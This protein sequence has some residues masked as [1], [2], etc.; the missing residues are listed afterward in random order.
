MAVDMHPATGAHNGYLR[1]VPPLAR[2]KKTW[3]PGLLAGVV[4]R[5][6]T[7][8]G[9]HRNV[10][11]LLKLPLLA[12]AA[13]ANP[14]FAYK[15]LTHDYLVRGLT[16]PQRASCFLHHYTRMHAALSRHNLRLTLHELVTLHQIYAEDNRFTL[17]MG[18]SRDFD[19]EGEFSLNL[20]VDTE[21]VFLLSYTLVP[22]ALSAPPLR[23]SSSFRV[24]RV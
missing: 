12:E 4:W 8:L 7:N 23:R 2:Y 11:R 3:A 15:Y 14:R 21:V 18:L 16:T 1:P 6:L 20:H 22:E 5:G 24:S 17:S 9:A 13:N 10:L 19:K